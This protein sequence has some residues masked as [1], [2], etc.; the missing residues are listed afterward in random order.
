MAFD[1]IV[2]TIVRETETSLEAK[3]MRLPDPGPERT[4]EGK[5]LKPDTPEA[6]KARLYE[7]SIIATNQA[8]SA[9]YKKIDKATAKAFLAKKIPDATN[10]QEEQR[11]MR[12]VLFRRLMLVFH[13]DKQDF[14]TPAL[15]AKMTE[16]NLTSDLCKIIIECKKFNVINYPA[17]A[18]K[19]PFD[20]DLRE[21]RIRSNVTLNYLLYAYERY[22][23]P[24]SFLV[25]VI[26]TVADF[27]FQALLFLPR[28]YVILAHDITGLAFYFLSLGAPYIAYEQYSGL[29][30]VY[31]EDLSYYEPARKKYWVLRFNE[32]INY[33]QRMTF[34]Q[35]IIEDIT[36]EKV[37]RYVINKIKN[38]MKCTHEKAE[39]KIEEEIK[40]SV[41]LTKFDFIG[42]I[43]RAIYDSVFVTPLPGGFFKNL[44][45]VTVIRPLRLLSMPIILCAMSINAAIFEAC[46]PLL[47]LLEDLLIALRVVVAV[48]VHW[49]IFL[50][51]GLNALIAQCVRSEHNS[52]AKVHTSEPTYN[53]GLEAMAGL[54]KPQQK[55][56]EVAE[57]A[58]YSF[59][60]VNENP[61]KD[62]E[63]EAEYAS[64]FYRH[65]EV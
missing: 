1:K 30:A 28:G 4:A 47:Y 16:F 41:Q 32:Y 55:V 20:S 36:E 11:K 23:F 43:A 44:L 35:I 46:D 58:Y 33:L 8:I 34:A 26:N 63:P 61:A 2:Q 15:N 40:N 60:F 10:L 57:S 31:T 51:D 62:K 49:P 12:N 65:L 24:F 52:G 5:L 64:D 39:Q 18:R 59:V 6:K 29:E 27:L 45:S 56:K 54:G 22:I 37:T 13:P 53:K 38:E 25:N 17:A 21:K 14:R 19:E 42:L 7:A 9:A 48:A 3:L 50:Y